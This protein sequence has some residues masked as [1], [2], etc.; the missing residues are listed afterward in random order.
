MVMSKLFEFHSRYG[1]RNLPDPHTMC[2]GQCEGLGLVPIHKD[3]DEEPWHTLWLAAEKENPNIPGDDY[4][5]VECPDCNGTGRI[6][7][8]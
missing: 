5:F 2:K 4:H 8:S 3:D 6:K 7:C 1:A